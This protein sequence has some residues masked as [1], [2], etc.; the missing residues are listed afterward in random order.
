MKKRRI[1]KRIGYLIFI[2]LI[3][4]IF[5]L[6]GPFNYF[7]DTLITTSMTT[8]SHKYIAKFLY[9][10]KTIKAVMKKNRVIENKSDTNI[11]IYE[12]K[13]DLDKEI[14]DR[15]ED[16]LYKVIKIEE[17]TYSGYLVAIYDPS[18][19]SLATSKYIGKKGE[20]ITTVAK[21][22][23][24][25]IM[26]NAG[27]FYDPNWNSNGSIPHGI[28]VKDSKIISNYPKAKVGGGIV[29]FDNKNRLILGEYTEEEI[30][31]KKIRDAVEFGPFLIRD[32]N[33][34]KIEG[35]GGWGVA[36]RTVIAQREDGTVLFLVI[37]GRSVKTIGASM[38]DLLDILLRCKAYNAANMDGGSSTE[39]L[40]NNKII[41]NPVAEGKNGLR[42]LPTFWMVK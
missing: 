26:M 42:K 2:L 7:R 31:E 4:G 15:K 40:I 28:V 12:G 8:K 13:T 9:S 41:N 1:R 23:N 21:D 16:E 6:Y 33:I 10:K 3:S 27:G 25:K 14:L 24:A 32:G 30:V 11:N 39:L 37:D 5:I 36:P 38:S 18:R 35:N 34:S 17:K 22:N 19:V 20:Y 29:G